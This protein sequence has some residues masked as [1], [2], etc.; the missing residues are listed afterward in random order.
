[1][2]GP[3]RSADVSSSNIHPDTLSPICPKMWRHLSQSVVVTC[4]V[5]RPGSFGMS[6]DGLCAWTT[7]NGVQMRIVAQS[8][9]DG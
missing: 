6:A 3:G 4:G 9:S 2:A 1:M 8:V 7:A 5:S